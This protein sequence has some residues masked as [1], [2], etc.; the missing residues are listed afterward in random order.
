LRQRWCVPTGNLRPCALC[1]P[2]RP[3]TEVPYLTI[4]LNHL[5]GLNRIG[6]YGHR[7]DE[8]LP[9]WRHGLAAVA[10][11]PNVYLKLGGIGMPRLGFD[12]HTRSKPIGSDELAAAMAPLMTYSIEQFGPNRCMFESNFPPDKVS[13]SHH[14]LYDAFKRFSQGYSAADRAALFRDTAVRA[15]RIGDV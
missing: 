13:F 14:I 4:I 11:C 15:Y 1:A 2:Q 6:P 3:G 10:A 12:W 8:V 7:D 9:T 5:G